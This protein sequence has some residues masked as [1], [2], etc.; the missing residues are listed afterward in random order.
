[1]SVAPVALGACAKAREDRARREAAAQ[2]GQAIEAYSRASDAA[3]NAHRDV[4]AA[5]AA[6]NAS[7][8]LPDYKAALRTRVLP[9]LDEFVARLAKMPADTPELKAIHARLIEAYR[10]ARDDVAEFERTLSDPR[11]LAQFDAIRARL[12]GAVVAYRNAL[13]DYYKRHDRQLRVDGAR[14]PA[15]DTTPTAPLISGPSGRTATSAP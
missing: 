13:A 9:A 1:L 15:A 2:V 5:F 11:G 4:I 7:G 14:E 8:N 12:Q 6:A 10:R 3:N